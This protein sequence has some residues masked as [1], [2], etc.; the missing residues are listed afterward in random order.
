MRLFL[1]T[2]QLAILPIV[3]RMATPPNDLCTAA[4][5][6]QVGGSCGFYDNFG[7]TPSQNPTQGAI[8]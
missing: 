4:M 6:I 5:E 8:Y 1:I 7:S 2:L 3:S